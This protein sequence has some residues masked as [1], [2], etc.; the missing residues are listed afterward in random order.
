MKPYV[1]YSRKSSESEDRQVLSIDSQI[2]ELEGLA[3]RLGLK[4]GDIMREAM[5]A[6]APGRP[7]FEKLMQRAE[8]GEIAGILCWKLD[9]L[10]R[11]P[12][13][14]GRIIWSIKNSGLSIVT[15]GQTYSP[16]DDNV[17]LMY[18]EFGMAQKYID[19][20]GKNVK[21]GNRAKLELG[22]YPGVAP[23]GYINKLDDHTI[24]PDPERFDLLRRM[25]DMYLGGQ[26]VDQ[27]LKTANKN[28]GFR[29]PQR[30]HRG[31]NPLAKS[32]LY[33]ILTSPFYY[34]IIER[35][36]HGQR[37]SFK[38][39][40]VPMITEDEFWRV[41]RM[42]GRPSPRPHK[43]AFAY[44]GM[45]RCG[46]CGFMVT[47]EHKTKKSGRSYTYY[48]CSRRSLAVVC[49]NPPVTL[50]EL[51]IQVSTILGQV[52]IPDEFSD[53]AIKWLRATNEGVAADK[54]A[55]LY[56][57]Q[58]AYGDNQRK[59]DRLTD[60]MLKEMLTDEEYAAKKALL[61]DEQH[62]LRERLADADQRSNNWLER[63]ERSFDFA[64]N[65]KDR[66]DVG[67]LGTKRQ[68]LSDLG[69]GFVLQNGNLT[70]E[71][72]ELWGCFAKHSSILF[73][74]VKRLELGE[75]A[76]D[77]KEP[78][79]FDAIGSLWRARRDSN[80]RPSP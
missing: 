11:N 41:Q 71:L 34:G 55:V 56:S 5:S 33:R 16:Q 75:K 80:P 61:L 46:E 36:D 52:R 21:R 30:K 42:M 48:R 74:D 29:T 73:E 14:G 70:L 50:S 8:S 62:S 15:P 31:G 47:A 49:H 7:V 1:I 13:D 59:I 18:V 24:I 65:A 38:G 6:K 25:W 22:W 35:L 32:S 40:H 44:T 54:S 19:D 76:Q 9:R 43:K 78:I 3:D 10:A 77:N 79:A 66:F 57:L 39:G 20:L 69:S 4:V 27:I 58:N 37:R 60:M 17:I 45:I 51:E 67:E 64:K 12:V 26:T 53:W 68:I 28:W 72:D 2:R 23:I 63:I